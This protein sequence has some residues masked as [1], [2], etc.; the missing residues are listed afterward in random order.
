MVPVL[1]VDRVHP[2]H[3]DLAP[4]GEGSPTRETNARN[5]PIVHAFVRGTLPARD[6]LKSLTYQRGINMTKTMTISRR[7]LIAITGGASALA[8][9]TLRPAWPVS[10]QSTTSPRLGDDQAA[11]DDVFGAGTDID[12]ALVQYSSGGDDEAIYAI[13]FTDDIADLIEVDLSGF[14]DGALPEESADVGQSRF[15]PDDATPIASFS[16]GDNG[17]ARSYDVTVHSS[18]SLAV[19]TGRTGNVLVLDIEQTAADGPNAVLGYI[20]A[21]VAMESSE[22]QEVVPVG[23]PAVIGDTVDDWQAA[24]GE[25]GAAQRFLYVDNPPISG[26]SFNTQVTPAAEQDDTPRGELP[27]A[28]IV[29]DRFG[30]EEWPVAEA[31][32]ELGQL[33]PEDSVLEQTYVGLPTSWSPLLRRVQVWS[34][35]SL[36]RRIVL[37]FEI[38]GDEE[39]GAVTKVVMLLNNQ[40]DL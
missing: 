34:A 10:A 4:V 35:P 14:A 7:R 37:L 20:S 38:D 23:A 22:V 2:E 21:T 40:Q 3:Q 33:L 12:A 16:G 27:V 11:F 36:D 39:S 29:I 28:Q 9:I 31:F 17:A 24:Y 32:A 15:L 1:A 13:R 18:E 19:D 26:L 25:G 8:A 5:H 30:D 6:L